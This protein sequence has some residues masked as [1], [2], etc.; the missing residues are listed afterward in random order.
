MIGFER[1]IPVSL[2]GVALHGVD[3]V[4]KL[5]R[6]A[7]DYGVGRIHMPAWDTVRLLWLIGAAAGATGAA[8][9]PPW[10]PAGSALLQPASAR[11][12]LALLGAQQLDEVLSS[13]A[14]RGV[15]G[16]VP[17]LPD[18][19]AFAHKTGSTDNYAADAGIVRADG[20]HYAVAVLSSLRIGFRTLAI[21]QRSSEVWKVLGAV[22]T[23][24][25]KFGDVLDKVKRQLETAGRT[26]DET[27]R[28]SRVMERKLRSV[29]EL[30]ADTAT[31]LLELPED[32][33]VDLLE[34][35]EDGAA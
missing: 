17:G 24:F 27:G 29:E 8:P 5:A 19:P 30:P 7:G 9:P 21:E 18:A 12:L 23:E 31:D 2:D 1:G 22:K 15:P 35:K 14:L 13:G 3:L 6:V 25:S 28:R 34:S 16:W 32:A 10:L 26:L 33:P 4:A 11:H 20:C